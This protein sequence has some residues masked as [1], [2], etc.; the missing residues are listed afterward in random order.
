MKDDEEAWRAG[1]SGS[2]CWPSLNARLP[3]ESPLV[4]RHGRIKRCRPCRPAGGPLVSL[5]RAQRHKPHRVEA[6]AGDASVQALD[7]PEV[8]QVGGFYV[9]PHPQ[10]YGWITAQDEG[11]LHARLQMKEVGDPHD[12]LQGET[13]WVIKPSLHAGVILAEI[14]T[15]P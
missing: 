7:A 15:E 3:H 2:V 4:R 10:G 14:L 8:L 6:R 9:E 5:P 13:D 1:T 11:M 12:A